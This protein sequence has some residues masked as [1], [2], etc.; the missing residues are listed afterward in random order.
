M[1][2]SEAEEE[3][4]FPL[5]ASGLHSETRKKC[6]KQHTVSGRRAA[7]P[8]SPACVPKNRGYLGCCPARHHRSAE[9]QAQAVAGQHLHMA[10]TC[11]QLTSGK[12]N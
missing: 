10:L 4:V 12:P 2:L 7:W 3:R 11:T 6:K 5:E 8:G 1:M 9:C